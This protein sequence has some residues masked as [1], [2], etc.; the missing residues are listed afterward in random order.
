VANASSFA[1]ADLVKTRDPRFEASIM[2]KGNGNSATMAYG[3]K[4][5]PR[6]ALTYIG[7]TYPAAYTSQTNTTDAPII[8]LAEVVLNWIEAKAVLAQ[9]F[10]GAA[11][12]QSDLDKSINAIRNRPLE[13]AAVAKG[14]KKTSLLVLTAIPNDPARDSDVPALIWEIRRERRMEF[15][16]EGF[17]LLDIKRWKKLDYMDFSKSP[18]YFLGPWVDLQ[19]E[20]FPVNYLTT[21]FI[22]KVKVKKADGTIVTWNGS[23]ASQMV[24]YFVVDN[25]AN[26]T[27]FAYKNYL[28]PVGQAQIVQYKDR[29]F[30]L[31]Q[32]TGW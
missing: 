24:G 23:N 27:A 32:T 26:R 11:V 6:E 1:L 15:V 7:K 22:N 25:A 13:A 2:D 16:F 10:G 21:G 17:R 18:D 19:V 12:T 20:N 9:Y 4:F 28:S 14:V 5:A 29:G 3:Y 31:T 8:R 30:T